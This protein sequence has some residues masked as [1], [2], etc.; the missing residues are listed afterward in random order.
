M[1]TNVQQT[2]LKA[3]AE[4]LEKPEQDIRLSASLRDDLGFDSLRQM[5]L[6]IL[7]EDEFHRSMAPEEVEGIVTVQDVIDF[8]NRKLQNP[9]PA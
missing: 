5:T 4:A 3:V 9:A 8:I 1:N 6:F 7:L 2:V